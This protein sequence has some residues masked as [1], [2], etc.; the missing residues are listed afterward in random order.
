MKYRQEV[1]GVMLEKSVY[2][3]QFAEP[4]DIKIDYTVRLHGDVIDED[5]DKKALA[6]RLLG[7]SDRLIKIA[8]FLKGKD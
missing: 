1:K 4:G 6:T 5:V 7:Y 2:A 8:N 3:E